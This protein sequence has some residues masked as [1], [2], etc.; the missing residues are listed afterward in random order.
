MELLLDRQEKTSHLIRADK[1]EL[2]LDRQ[3]KI[4]HRIAAKTR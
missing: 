2:L 4:S 3:E 1:I